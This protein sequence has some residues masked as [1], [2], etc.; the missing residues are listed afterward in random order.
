MRNI[1]LKSFTTK[2]VVLTVLLFQTLSCEKKKQY[3]DGDFFTGL[4][5]YNL[6]LDPI[7]SSFTPE[8][9][10]TIS[11]NA[12][13]G[14]PEYYGN[15]SISPSVPPG[16]QCYY[17]F[18]PTSSGLYD[19]SAFGTGSGSSAS[20]GIFHIGLVGKTP[21]SIP[22]T[23]SSFD[24]ENLYTNVPANYSDTT[25]VVTEPQFYQSANTT[26]III[27]DGTNCTS[28]CKIGLK[29]VKRGSDG[30]SST[31]NVS[32]SGTGLQG[33]NTTR[34]D[35]SGI[36]FPSIFTPCYFLFVSPKSTTMQLT[37]TRTDSGGTTPTMTLSVSAAVTSSASTFTSA[38][39]TTSTTAATLNGL[40][41]PAG[42]GRY[43]E[44][45]F[46]PTPSGFTFK[47]TNSY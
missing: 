3:D 20:K 28:N 45:K 29:I 21:T 27:A 43:I 34:F 15:I 22:T 8:T 13:N 18:T 16:K 25:A 19:F 4:F 10:V 46:S 38:S 32:C 35:E 23:T 44:A 47:M 40:V 14:Y 39:S 6:A 33:I 1:K 26:R 9:A 7:C 5:L 11:N 30:G 24:T 17:K 37:Q 2:A 41:T 42:S 31:S 12:S 36:S